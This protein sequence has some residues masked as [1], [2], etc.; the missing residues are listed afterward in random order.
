MNQ[1]FVPAP[2]VEPDDE[3]DLLALLGTLWRGKWIVLM[4]AVLSMVLGGVYAFRLAVPLYPATVTVALNAQQQ[5]V[6]TDIESIL[7]G[8]AWDNVAINTELEVLRSRE[9]VGQLVDRLDRHRTQS[10]TRP[11]E[12]GQGSITYVLRCWLRFR[13]DPPRR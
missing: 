7:G 3:I 11:Y 10:S 9:L 1:Q 2:D 8:G 13:A 4:A 5:Q 6:I 12:F